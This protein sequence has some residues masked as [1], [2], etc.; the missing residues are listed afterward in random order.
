MIASISSYGVGLT[1]FALASAAAAR[2][3][4]RALSGPRLIVDSGLSLNRS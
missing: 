1:L 4:K 3:A 2:T